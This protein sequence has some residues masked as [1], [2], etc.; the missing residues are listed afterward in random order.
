MIDIFKLKQKKNIGIQTGDL[1]EFSF[2]ITKSKLVRLYYSKC[3]KDYV[4]SIKLNNS[5]KIIITRH[6]WKVFRKYIN[7]I[8]NELSK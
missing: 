8:D 1:I 3:Y 6:M 4:L 7:Q 5:K 2:L